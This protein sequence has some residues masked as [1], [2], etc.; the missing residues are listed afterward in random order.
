MVFTV[1]IACELLARQRSE[2]TLPRQKPLK[3]MKKNKGIEAPLQNEK[4]HPK[5]EL[6]GA[7]IEAQ[8][9]PGGA[10]ERMQRSKRAAQRCMTAPGASEMA[11]EVENTNFEPAKGRAL[12]THPENTKIPR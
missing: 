8:I 10:L 11:K 2:T 9:A 4:L 5:M 12:R 7:Q 1:R 6:S 3:M